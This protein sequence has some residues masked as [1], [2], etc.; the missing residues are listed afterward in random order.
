MLNLMCRRWD[1]ENDFFVDYA[2]YFPLDPVAIQSAGNTVRQLWVPYAA[3]HTIAG[4][5]ATFSV[6]NRAFHFLRHRK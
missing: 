4:K 6:T 2:L 1:V 5:N 3:C